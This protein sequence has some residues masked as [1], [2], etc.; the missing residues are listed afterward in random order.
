VALKV[1]RV[2]DGSVHIEKALSR[3][4]RVE[5]L[6]FSL[7]SSHDLTGI[8]GAIVLPQSLLMRTGQAQVPKSRSVGA[9]LVRS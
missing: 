7:S 1:E 5:P 2:M 4:S 8:L 9:E 6:H 3:A